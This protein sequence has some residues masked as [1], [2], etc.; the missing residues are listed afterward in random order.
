[1]L[2]W[3]PLGERRESF[4]CLVTSFC[5]LG[6]CH[7]LLA[8]AGSVLDLAPVT[9]GTA[10]DLN[11]VYLAQLCASYGVCPGSVCVYVLVLDTVAGGT[12]LLDA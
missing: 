10:S 2:P 12:A 5:R 9:A 3:F 11:C 7:P 8:S 6:T 4:Y 1:M